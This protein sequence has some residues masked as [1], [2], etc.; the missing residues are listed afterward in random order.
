MEKTRG[1]TMVFQQDRIGLRA[2]NDRFVLHSILLVQYLGID[3]F[4]QGFR[5]NDLIQYTIS[6]RGHFQAYSL[7]E[8]VYATSRP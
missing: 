4:R 2:G 5:L 1:K 7:A 6:L 8:G 3:E